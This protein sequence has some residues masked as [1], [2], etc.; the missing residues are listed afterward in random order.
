MKK[1]QEMYKPGISIKNGYESLEDQMDND[2][3]SSSDSGDSSGSLMKRRHKKR[4]NKFTCIVDNNGVK[5]PKFNINGD[6]KWGKFIKD[7]EKKCENRYPND[8]ERWVQELG[9]ALQGE[10]KIMFTNYGGVDESYRV[11]KNKLTEYADRKKPNSVFEQAKFTAMTMERGETPISYAARLETV[12]RREYPSENYLTSSTLLRKFLETTPHAIGLRIKQN[13]H[14]MKNLSG[15]EPNWNIVQDWI[16]QQEQEMDQTNAGRPKTMYSD[17]LKGGHDSNPSANQYASINYLGYG[18]RSGIGNKV[19]CRACNGTGWYEKGTSYGQNYSMQGNRYGYGQ[20]GGGSPK[21]THCS[22]VGHDFRTC[23]RRLGQCLACGS[24]DHYIRT[25]PKRNQRP[26]GKID[27]YICSENHFAKD[28]P[29]RG[30]QASTGA[31]TAKASS[32]GAG[33]SGNLK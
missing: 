32:S 31:G 2:S 26:L 21:C 3:E 23:R 9:E 20:K 30:N 18:T 8:K 29:Q 22:R 28:C 4:K 27:C 5:I 33:Q 1:L 6:K 11:I 16:M 14:H 12:F 24:A 10:I 13:Y 7:F 17:I 15:E 19:Q 25:C